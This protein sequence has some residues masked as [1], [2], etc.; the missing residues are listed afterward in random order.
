MPTFALPPVVRQVTAELFHRLLPTY[1]DAVGEI[2]MDGLTLGIRQAM[3]AEC[4]EVAA[5]L[6][7]HAG[8]FALH[9]TVESIKRA[10]QARYVAQCRENDAGGRELRRIAKKQQRTLVSF[11]NAAGR[12][13][14]KY[15][16]DLTKA[17]LLIVR[18][19]YAKGATAMAD[20]VTWCDAVYTQM[21]LLGLGDDAMVREVVQEEDAA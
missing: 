11:R 19:T 13:V 4:P 14:T 1:R 18:E 2:D 17:E 12:L 16:L 8:M 6:D 7:R 9:E 21:D 15:R 5:L 10:S 3:D 20:V